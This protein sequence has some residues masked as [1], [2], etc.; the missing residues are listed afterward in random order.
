MTISGKQ[1]LNLTVAVSFTVALALVAFFSVNRL[2]KMSEAFGEQT[3]LESNEALASVREVDQLLR[4]AIEVQLES[5][6][7]QKKVESMIS[8]LGDQVGHLAGEFEKVSNDL[9]ETNRQV[10]IAGLKAKGLSGVIGESI[11]SLADSFEALPTGDMR[12]DLEDVQDELYDSQELLQKEVVMS[13]RNSN[14]SLENSCS[15]IMETA[16][17]VADLSEKADQQIFLVGEMRAK[18]NESVASLQQSIDLSQKTVE[19][20]SEILQRCED[21][22]A[23]LK[24]YAKFSRTFLIVVSVF[25]ILILNLI[26]LLISK[27]AIKD[28]QSVIA[29]LLRNKKRTQ[30]STIEINQVGDSLASSA[31]SLASVSLQISSCV[32]G[33]CEKSRMTTERAVDAKGHVDDVFEATQT[34]EVRMEAMQRAMDEI[35]ESSQEIGGILSNI[36]AVAF[37]TNLL[38]LNAA[39]EAARAGEAGAGFAVVAEEVRALANRS[40][41]AAGQ[42]AEVVSKTQS[43]TKEG[44]EH[45][46]EAS[47]GLTSVLDKMKSM[48]GSFSSI[49]RAAD[50][51]VHGLDELAGVVNEM[52]RI[53]GNMT[54]RSSEATHAGKDLDRQLRGFDRQITSLVGMVGGKDTS[55]NEKSKNEKEATAVVEE[56]EPETLNEKTEPNRLANVDF[57][58]W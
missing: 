57:S 18:T 43:L 13:L 40:S 4:R 34:M 11:D 45:C 53:S 29:S 50:E 32:E 23:E 27:S 21:T 39:V 35:H 6:E 37:Q 9:G 58:D 46:S 36:E 1:K 20:Q 25:S 14:V 49:H 19:S 5:L 16:E 55:K 8:A 54:N 22:A 31:S 26:A 48:D 3:R 44:K 30:C 17:S 51:Q 33:V 12:Y 52:E 56:K 10:K 7:E 42:T 2:A 41:K 28:L 47:L 24:S 38:A 15:R